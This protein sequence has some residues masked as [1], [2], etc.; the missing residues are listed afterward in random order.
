[1]CML[2]RTFIRYIGN[3]ALNSRMVAV[4]REPAGYIRLAGETP[5]GQPIRYRA[6][7]PETGCTYWTSL[8]DVIVT[9]AEFDELAK[10]WEGSPCEGGPESVAKALRFMGLADA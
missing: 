7:E 3:S 10:Q 5:L 2:K 9:P 6:T 8:K 4:Y 1:M